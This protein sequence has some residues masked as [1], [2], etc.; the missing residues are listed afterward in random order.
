MSEVSKIFELIDERDAVSFLQT[1]VGVNSV[2]PPGSEKAV[3]EVIEKRLAGSGL[4]FEVDEI[5]D[6]RANL[7]VSSVPAS[8]NQGNSDRVL[9]YSGHFDT[10]PAGSSNWRRNPFGGEEVENRIYGRGT[11][12]MK[13]GV[14]AM[15]LALEYLHYSGVELKGSLRFAGTAG[16]EVD[17]AGA[18]QIVDKGQLDDATAMVVGEPSLNEAY[19]AHKGTL[20]LEVSTYGRSAHGSMPEQGVNAID[21]MMIFLN[22]LREYSF[23]YESHP[24]LG[25]PTVNVGTIGGGSST[26]VVADQCTATLDIRMVPGQDQDRIISDLEKLLERACE[27]LGS[28][29]ELR[30]TNAKAPV[31][32]PEDDSF[33]QLSIKVAKKHFNKSLSVGGANYYTDASVYSGYLDV[34]FLIY[35]PGTPEMAHQPDEWI[36]TDNYIESIRFYIAL[37]LEYLNDVR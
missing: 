8:T 25:E 37:A 24:M 10:V 32:T 1:L 20:W 31:S 27:P 28:S 17:G 13:G 34:P 26:N 23:T 15:V 35:G 7:L 4:E 33:V 30:V 6:G 19:I 5:E 14:A 16:E 9:I 11:T 18:R 29:Y 2:N 36:D 21:S 12:D 3:A 22:E